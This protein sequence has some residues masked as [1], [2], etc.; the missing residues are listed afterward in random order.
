VSV[1]AVNIIESPSEADLL[2]NRNEGNA[3][4]E[5][6]RL[7][8]VAVSLHAAISQK[9]FRKALD[10][11]VGWYDDGP[12]LWDDRTEEAVPVIHIS[13]HGNC[14]GIAFSNGDFLDWAALLRQ[15]RR[16]ANALEMPFV[17]SVSCCEGYSLRD[18]FTTVQR[19][20][21]CCL[22]GS[23]SKPTWSQ[24]LVGFSTMY[25]QMGVGVN[26]LDAVVAVRVAAMHHEFEVA[27]AGGFSA[28][29]EEL[30]RE[31]RAGTLSGKRNRAG[32]AL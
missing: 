15:L 26:P 8:E 22:I 3:L 21:F 5:S 20:P 16:F 9:G 25:Y 32:R 10:A 1:I 12:G 14:D 19:S 2:A 4:C 13:C 28:E 24:T 23:K 30:V 6:L 29:W 7:H 27:A 11:I 18:Q 17:L 31:A